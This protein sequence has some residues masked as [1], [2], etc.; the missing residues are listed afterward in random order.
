MLTINGLCASDYVIIPVKSEYVC[1][2]GLDSLIQTV[3]DVKDPANGMNPDLQIA[4]ANVSMYETIIKDQREVLDL[5]SYKINVL[6][7]VKKTADAYRAVVDGL[8]VVQAQKSSDA[9]RAYMEISS[10]I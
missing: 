4:G 10:N 3:E 2:R 9:A 8:P 5:I 7:I 6:C 1:Y